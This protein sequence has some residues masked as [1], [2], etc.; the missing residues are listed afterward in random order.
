M[1]YKRIYM[2]GM[3][4][5][6]LILPPAVYAQE[7]IAWHEPVPVEIQ[8]EDYIVQIDYTTTAG[9]RYIKIALMNTGWGWLSLEAGTLVST[10]GSGSIIL[11]IS[12]VPPGTY[13]MKAILNDTDQWD[14]NL[15]AIYQEHI[16]LSRAQEMIWWEELLTTIVNGEYT[17]NIGYY[18][19]VSRNIRFEIFTTDGQSTGVNDTVPVSA[20]QGVATLTV[21]GLTP[22]TYDFEASLLDSSQQPLDAI[23]HEYITIITS[24][25]TYTPTVDPNVT[26]ETYALFLNLQTIGT[27][28]H[29]I[30]GQEFPTDF[31]YLTGLNNSYSQSDCKD[32]VGDHPGVHGTDFHYYLDKDAAERT[33]HTQAVQ[34]AYARNAVI[35]FDWHMYG[36]YYA[37]YQAGNGN[38]VLVPNIVDNLNGDRAWL[39]NQLDNAIA[40]INALGFPIVFRPFHEMNGNWFWWGTFSTP[41]DY[42]AFYRLTV[43]YMKRQGVHNVLFCWSPNTPLD[44]DYY[45]GDAYVDVLGVDI[46]E[47]GISGGIS[48]ASMLAQLG[49]LVA[50]A[51]A[52]GKVAVFSE[53][54]A[55]GSQ[56]I[57]YNP[58]FWTEK[59]LTPISND[60]NAR[61]IAWVL[62]WINGGWEEPYIPYTGFPVQHAITDFQTFFNDSTTL[63]ESDLP[64]MYHYRSNKNL[65]PVYLLLGY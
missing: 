23:D 17:A 48:T 32:I 3:L 25:T 52:H 8:G 50:Y 20:G 7:S 18:A 60:T 15:R 26:P 4:L 36:R 14:P 53:T 30:F 9:N 21:T 37:D 54:G 16:T 29:F 39:Y 59:I 13:H 46:Y 65:A 41:E 43:D 44:F 31:S 61:K 10:A 51:A 22:G 38:N 27:S 12:G 45:P 62:T 24:N 34:Q 11:T 64:D 35:T 2:L 55:R 40:I 5:W 19:T 6:W 47:P 56:S 33:I 1:S 28:N 57:R 63:F 49:D 58:A 42:Q